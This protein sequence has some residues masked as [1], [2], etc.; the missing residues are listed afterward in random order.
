MGLVLVMVRREVALALKRPLFWIFLLVT[1]FV[2]IIYFFGGVAVE[3]SSGGRAADEVLH[4]NGPYALTIFYMAL[5]FVV[6]TL[7]AA[8][9]MATT[10]VR[11]EQLGI[12]PA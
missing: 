11:D 8:I 6:A 7:F 10:V 12:E 1:L 5:P 2:S 3:V 4:V 9:A